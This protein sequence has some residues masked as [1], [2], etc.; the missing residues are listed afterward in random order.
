MEY[1]T[2]LNKVIIYLIGYAGCGKLTI[3]NEILKKTPGIIID[4][5]TIINPITRST[6]ITNYGDLPSFSK[7]NVEKIREIIFDNLTVLENKSNLYV[8]TNELFN[9]VDIDQ[10]IYNKVIAF[11]KKIHYQIFPV[12]MT[13]DPQEHIKRATSI[14]RTNRFKDTNIKTIQARYSYKL[15][16]CKHENSFLIDTS[17]LLAEHTARKILDMILHKINN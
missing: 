17:E 16:D 7:E 12:V 11:A 5:Q 10:K 15:L 13:C 14:K 3:A 1:S 6:N 8:F 9:N 2:K 4:N